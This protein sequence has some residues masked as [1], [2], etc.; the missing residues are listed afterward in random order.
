[1][2]PRKTIL[3]AAGGTAGHI[4]PALSIAD[5]CRTRRPEAEIFFCGTENGLEAKMVERAGFPFLPI[6]ASPFRRELSGA[7]LTAVRDLHRGRRECTKIIREKRADL[8]V[9]TG[10]YVCAPLMAAAKK[11][12]VKRLIHEQNVFAGRSNRLT[13][14]GADCVCISFEESAPFFRRAKKVRVTGNPVPEALFQLERDRARQKL[15]IRLEEGQILILVT[16]GSL[17]A[18]RLNRAVLDLAERLCAQQQTPALKILLAAGA[19]LYEECRE[20]FHEGMAPFLE[21]KP[22]IYDMPDHMAA[23]DLL[24]SRAGAISCAEIAAIGRASIM[25]PYP[26]AA[27]DHQ[28]YNARVFEAAG[29]ARLCKDELFDVDYLEKTIREILAEKDALK[30]MGAAARQLAK[31]KALP[32]ILEEIDALLR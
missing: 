13:G 4:N 28:T 24:I 22:Y 1:M 17:G 5:A 21:I 30:T 11:E 32:D 26:Y 6:H 10:G 3:F 12:G 15:G 14:R 23:A 20:R 18:R 29:A 7:L 9:G 27:E 19:R 16:G 2:K 8:C 31:A 25:V